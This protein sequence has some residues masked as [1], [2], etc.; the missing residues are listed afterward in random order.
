MP[1]LKRIRLTGWKSI[2]DQTI[3]L[4]PLNVLIG[5]NGAGKSNLISFLRFLNAMVSEPP[6]LQEFVGAAGGAHALLHFGADR[7][8]VLEA[9]M[10]FET[11]TGE[12][13]YY[14]RWTHAAGNS[15]VFA[16]EQVQLRRPGVPPPSYESL[17]AGHTE[18][19]L[20]EAT[21]RGDQA[22]T[23]VLDL[24]R[25]C[26]VYH[27]HNTSDRSPL[28]SSCYI[29]ANRLLYP[30]GG[31]LPAMLYL[32]QQ[33][34]PAA[35]RRIVSAVRQAIPQFGAFVLGPQLLNRRNILL[36]WK[37]R[38]SD[39][40]F[41]PHDLSDGSIRFIALT[42]L[43]SQP[44]ELL[45]VLI[46]LDEPEL[47]LHPAAMALLAG[48]A[49]ASAMECQLLLATQ[50]PGLLDYFEPEEVVVVHHREGESQF[51]RLDPTDLKQWLDEYS[52]SEL[53]E[54]NVVGG[55]PYE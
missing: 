37:Q 42:V 39:Y 52:L 5:G 9:D 13:R 16:D 6:R 36:N 26:R 24:L 15:L 20:L 54:K 47:G 48:M 18:S 31:N 33:R 41:G 44:A 23:A 51:A 35:L 43:L 27:F 12:I 22:A 1:L 8:P 38:G 40:E 32:F 19:K 55:G 34:Y 21:D 10:R 14:A 28:R 2:R 53:W 30:D 7:T 25:A 45:P 3:E 29:E 11:D 17:G 4:R 46:A 49:K 50:S